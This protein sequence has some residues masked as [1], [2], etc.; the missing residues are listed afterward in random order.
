MSITLLI[1]SRN[2]PE[3]F[4]AANVYLPIMFLEFMSNLPKKFRNITCESP[5]LPSKKIE[6]FLKNSKT[7]KNAND[8][9]WNLFLR[10]LI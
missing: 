5:E 4:R 3:N 1:K 6:T 2:V 9:E 8:R 10:S 7:E